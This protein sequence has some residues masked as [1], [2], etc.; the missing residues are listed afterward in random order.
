MCGKC[1]TRRKK[2]DENMKPRNVAL[3][4]TKQLK[5]LKMCV[6]NYRI[7][8]DDK[9][10]PFHDKFD[11][12]KIAKVAATK[13][14]LERERKQ[15]LQMFDD[16]DIQKFLDD[17]END[18]Q[19]I[20]DLAFFKNK[21][22][23]LLLDIPEPQPILTCNNTTT[24][25][26]I[27]NQQDTHQPINI[28]EKREEKK[29]EEQSE[30]TILEVFD[31][32]KMEEE[33]LPQPTNDWELKEEKL[34]SSSSL[35]TNSPEQSPRREKQ[36]D[37][38]PSFNLNENEPCNDFSLN[39]ESLEEHKEGSESSKEPS[40]VENIE[41]IFGRSKDSTR[42]SLEIITEDNIT[43]IIQDAPPEVTEKK[44]LKLL[45]TNIPV[46]KKSSQKTKKSLEKKGDDCI[47]V[48]FVTMRTS[49]DTVS[50]EEVLSQ[51]C[52]EFFRRVISQL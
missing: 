43:E 4:M 39:E 26:D 47:D 50:P 27:E 17:V 1:Y 25:T 45:N 18:P 40:E 51:E 42:P 52:V 10:K 37:H 34:M 16:L 48:D 12:L 15:F 20:Q 9:S 14:G 19:Q 44:P 28:F 5:H 46:I 49:E 21:F 31:N 38:T 35:S 6:D 8:G 22:Q 36:H 33:A 41:S 2:S 7:L 11:L 23:D 3:D 13:E 29:Q 30:S 32:S 24:I